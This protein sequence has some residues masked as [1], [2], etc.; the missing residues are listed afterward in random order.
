[1]PVAERYGKGS[2]E[3]VGGLWVLHLKGTSFER[4]LQHGTL[5]RYRVRDT[6]NFYR[7]LPDLLASR[8]NSEGSLK[9]KALTRSK[10]SMVRRLSK[11][12]DPD[13]LEEIRGL[14]VGLGLKTEDLAEALVLADVMQ[15]A[16]AI[17]ERSRRAGPPVLPGFGCTSAIRETSSGGLIFGRNFDFWGAGYWDANPA[18]LFH[19]PDKGKAFC[20]IT[21]AGFP[22]GGITSI[23][24]DGLAV[25]IHQHGSRD[26]SPK[27]TPIVDIAHNIVR[28][29]SNLEEALEIAGRFRATGGWSIVIAGGSRPDAA[30]LEVSSALQKER[31]LTEGSLVASNYFLDEELSSRELQSNLSATISD[32]LRF[33][34][35]AQLVASPRIRPTRMAGLLGDHYDILAERERSAGFSISRITTLSSVIFSLPEKHFWVSES[36]APTSKGG[37]VGFD[38]DAELEGRRSTL[39]RI[40]G[41]RPPGIKITAAQEKYL[42]AYKEY[43]DSGDLNMVLMILGECASLDPSEPTFPLME[44]IVRGMVGNYRGALSAVKR[45]LELEKVSLKKDVS[46]L[47]KARIL[48]LLDHRE[49]SVKIYEELAENPESAPII[50]RAASRGIRNPFVEGDLGSLI[51]DFTDGD[52]FE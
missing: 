21:T 29:A 43:I 5:M 44:C 45:A 42:E 19:H 30:V 32:H 40:E 38:L 13:A 3:R 7:R 48:D 33:S 25:A 35:A 1:V 9:R 47:W 6:I 16:G 52:T 37:Y 39:E 12:R 36:S 10:N 23:N 31:R 15:A 18:V 24:E 27:G 14:A 11:N 51:I 4:G 28:N 20:S 50:V 17:A 22:T 49:Q 41:G 26:A 46:L 2:A 34:R 8:L